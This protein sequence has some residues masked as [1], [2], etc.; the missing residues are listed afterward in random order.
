MRKYTLAAAWLGSAMSACT[1]N[2]VVGSGEVDAGPDAHA[3]LDATVVEAGV[4]AADG[5]AGPVDAADAGLQCPGTRIEC[6]GVCIECTVDKALSDYQSRNAVCGADGG[7]ATACKAQATLCTPLGDAGGVATCVNLDN[8]PNACG[9]CAQRCGLGKGSSVP[10]QCSAGKC[11]PVAVA[12]PSSVD[13]ALVVSN[14]NQ[15]L[16]HKDN[17]VHRCS[18]PVCASP[19]AVTT[20]TA[21]TSPTTSY[22]IATAGLQS[23]PYYFANELSDAGLP[24]N[25]I[26]RCNDVAC[27]P[28]TKHAMRNGLGIAG[29][30]NGLFLADGAGALQE[31]ALSVGGA[32]TTLATVGTGI[33][34]PV[35]TPAHVYFLQ[36]ASGIIYRCPRGG[37]CTSPEKVVAS[38]PNVNL[39]YDVVNDT[40]FY[41][42][43]SVTPARV[44]A[45]SVTATPLNCDPLK[46]R[47]LASGLPPVGAVTADARAVYFTNRGISSCT[48]LVNGCTAAQLGG[49]VTG[50]AERSGGVR[51]VGEFIYWV[52][53]DTT[54]SVNVMRAHVPY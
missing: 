24:V 52:Q 20:S 35:V 29:D 7:C 3:A 14:L 26:A 18:L 46:A 54:K 4:D 17:Q 51:A 40:L 19:G 11:V 8:D 16:F 15:I 37:A 31:I 45:C 25:F 9:S 38:L 41:A 22:G 48:D 30:T 42:D 49:Y 2:F 44:L 43:N 27:S 5:D 32:A 10:G 47:V 50:G 6:N 28:P 23:L 12:S 39:P 13:S 53:E 1:A 33:S 21:Y 34:R 36:Q